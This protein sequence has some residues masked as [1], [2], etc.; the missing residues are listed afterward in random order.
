MSEALE[1]TVPHARDD[2]GIVAARIG[3]FLI[4][5]RLGHGGM[6][7]VYS[8]YDPELDRKVAVKVLRHTDADAEARTRMQ[9]EARAMARLSDPH[10]VA[11]YDAGIHEGRV[12]IAMELVKGRTLRQ[13]LAADRPWRDVIG[14][15]VQA[16]QGL[17]AAH[18][19]GI[20]HRDF[21]PENVLVGVDERVRVTDFGLSR[22]NGLAT[23]G[24]H[25]ATEA[26]SW[27]VNEATLTGHGTLVGTPAYM[28]PEQVMGRA[29]DMRSDQFSFCVALWEALY[30]K[31]PFVGDTLIDLAIAIEAAKLPALPDGRAPAWIGRVLVRGLARDPADRFPNMQSL[32]DAL[33]ADLSVRRRRVLGVAAVIAIGVLGFV[34]WRAHVAELRTTCETESRALDGLWNADVRAR[35]VAAHD[36]L[37]YAATILDKATPWLDRYAEDWAGTSE[38]VCLAGTVDDSIE[39][40]EAARDCL[41]DGRAAYATLVDSL[42]TAPRDI[43][44]ASV[45]RAA[46]LPSVRR[47]EDQQWLALEVRP[48]SKPGTRERV[49]EIRTQLR[50]ATA[51]EASRRFAEGRALAE[52]SLRDAETLGWP[53]LVAEA[54]FR[55]GL[56]EQNEF[57]AAQADVERAWFEAAKAGHDRLAAAAAIRLALMASAT[58][59]DD[60]ES[61]SRWLQVADVFATRAGADPL[62]MA[63]L[64]MTRGRSLITAHSAGLA[65]ANEAIAVLEH[66]LALREQVLGTEH[67]SIADT[68]DA[69][70]NAHAQAGNLEE[71]LRLHTRALAVGEHVLGPDHWSLRSY[72]NNMAADKLDLEDF[73]GARKVYVRVAEVLERNDARGTEAWAQMLLG[74]G[75]ADRL[76]KDHVAAVAAFSEALPI[77]ERLRGSDHANVGVTEYKRAQSFDA[78]GLPGGATAGFRRA[79]AI[80]GD[81]SPLASA[82]ALLGLGDVAFERGAFAEAF[83]HYS[84]AEQQALRSVEAGALRAFDA[85]VGLS[86]AGLGKSLRR[87]GRHGEA[88]PILWR[89][90]LLALLANRT[91][92]LDDDARDL[93]TELFE[94]ASVLARPPP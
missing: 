59:P 82:N 77:Y 68:L 23:S 20:V 66:A 89:A 69:L 25:P 16:G 84:D 60:L 74:I 54:R 43:V 73:D 42:E 81:E 48:P 11:V 50:A 24:T 71:A 35:I 18:A 57:A 1:S 72:L 37:A 83:E 10:V 14:A 56:L 45:A 58:A 27:R 39:R 12:F 6:G 90:R 70:G 7:V 44:V 2:D 34:A 28:S 46:S 62:T 53:P 17:A 19:A 51:A 88:I 22:A 49:A 52:T 21:K 4:L 55:L 33:Q 93:D 85:Q 86:A 75:D 3:R 5:E 91:G 64:A 41:E 92:E 29:A 63:E 9:R 67:P 80:A 38:R 15:F 40:Y 30:G 65:R 26:T 87:L 31:R 8:A 36:D 13:W 61:S 94:A 78:L 79:L 32:I 47:C 76:A